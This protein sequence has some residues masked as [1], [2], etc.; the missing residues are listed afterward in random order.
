[1]INQEISGSGL[2]LHK[3]SVKKVYNSG[4][5]DAVSERGNKF[6]RIPPM[7][8][9][10]E[11]DFSI[12]DRVAVLTD[13]SQHICI[14]EVRGITKDLNGNPTVR[15]VRN[16]LSDLRDA[17][18]IMVEDEYGHQARVVVSRG[19]GII[20][21]AGDWCVQNF[22]P[23]LDKLMSYFERKETVMPG[24][25]ENIDRQ[26]DLCSSEYTWRT[27]SDME[28]I[29]RDLRYE[30]LPELN[31]AGNPLG[32]HTLNA[33]IETDPLTGN[34]VAINLLRAIA[35]GPSVV[36]A[37]I[38][39]KDDGALEIETL[40]DISIAAA[41]GVS[42]SSPFP[43]SVSSEAAISATAP[44][45]VVD[46]PVVQL[47]SSSASEPAAKGSASDLNDGRIIVELNKLIAYVNGIVPGTALPI[48]S[49]TPSSATKVLV[50]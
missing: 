45:V 49:I 3:C 42:V 14:G 34:V 43:V 20:I 27:T 50:E 35:G 4:V 12:G 18:V 16:D 8:S 17:K 21:D 6:N 24:F 28:V 37:T 39:I 1:M 30:T 38:N 9:G 10:V 33:K 11:S 15:N 40:S 44:N 47:G 19:A 22:A 26:G 5:I 41:A 36:M 7:T 2:Q 31:F 29:R 48:E 32:G 46:S 13:G 23:G 25:C